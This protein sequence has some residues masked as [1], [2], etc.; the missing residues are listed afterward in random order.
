MTSS[1]IVGNSESITAT[2]NSEL[3]H[4]RSP[5]SILVYNQFADLQTGGSGEF[6]NT[7][8]SIRNTY[9][10]AQTVFTYENLTDF[11]ELEAKLWEYDIF[12]IPEQEYLSLENISDIADVW[13][14]ILNEWANAGGIV[15]LMDCYSGSL[16]DGPTSRIYNQ[17]G[18]MNI[19]PYLAVSSTTVYNVNLTS[20]LTQG[21]AATWDT[22]NG[23][24]LFNTTDGDIVVDDGTYAYVAHKVMGKGHVVM[25]GFDMFTIGGNESIILANAIRLHHNIVFDQSHSATYGINNQFS[26]LVEDLQFMGFACSAMTTFNP[27]YLQAA[28]VLVLFSS[29]DMYTPSEVSVIEVF[30]EGGGGLFVATDWNIYGDQLDPVIEAFGFARNKT[31]PLRDSD[32]FVGNT[33]QFALNGENIIFHSATMLVNSVEIYGGTGFVQLPDDAVPLIV[34]DSDGTAT[35]DNEMIANRTPVSAA[36]TVGVGRI[37]VFGDTNAMDDTSDT[38]SDGQTNYDDANNDLFFMNSFRW[39]SAAGLEEVSVVFDQSHS[40]NFTIA[41]SLLGIARLMTLNGFTIY[42]IYSL[43]GFGTEDTSLG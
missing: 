21:V 35:F 28:D 18:L 42:R 23:G 10:T 27:S 33:A 9:V 39:L 26:S 7:M 22:A 32:D 40:P 8:T 43:L 15:I 38:D 6:E 3:P 20:A 1:D 11:T 13:G 34:T 17:T 31:D 41:G 19:E 36:L 25:L 12:L 24:L 5:V 14:P 37:I 16:G 2:D 30:V 29:Y 4:H